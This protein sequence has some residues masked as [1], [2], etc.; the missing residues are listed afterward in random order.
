M[1]IIAAGCSFSDYLKNNNLVYGEVLAQVLSKNFSKEIPYIHQG[2]GA[3]SNWRIWRQIT[4]MVMEK[5]ITPDDLLFIQYTGLERKEFWSRMP[6][7][8]TEFKK[9]NVRE[10]YAKGGTIL[11]F[12]FFCHSWHKDTESKFFRLYE[13]NHISAD[14]CRE[15]FETQH[16]MFQCMLKEHNIKTIFMHTRHTQNGFLN[17]IPHFEKWKFTEDWD[18]SNDVKYW[19]TPTDRT[20]I[21]DFGHSDFAKQLYDHLKKIELI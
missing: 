18:K 10:P 4:K 20:H 21:S 1:K 14:F 6:P 2:A 16:L 9:V 19:N 11:R 8:K 17:L 12:K 7:E 5:D 13:N 15:Q 3:G